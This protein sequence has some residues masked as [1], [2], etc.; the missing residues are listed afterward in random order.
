M[1]A[2]ICSI[3]CLLSNCLYAI[4]NPISGNITPSPG[5][6]ETYTIAWEN[7]NS[8]H[9]NMADVYWMVSNGTVLS[10]D[11][12]SATI[13]WN[14]TR[15]INEEGNIT[16][17]ENTWS[18]NGFLEVSL[19][20]PEEGLSENCNGI[21][22]QPLVFESFGSGSNPGPAY[23]NCSYAYKPYC[24]VQS[25]EYTR[26]N[27]TFACRSLWR[28]LPSDHTPND[29][30]GYMLLIDGDDKRGI[31]FSTTV[32]TGLTSSFQ[33]EFS[34][35][36]ANLTSG[37]GFE[38]PKVRFEIF[39]GATKIAESGDFRI[40]YD[41]N[42]PWQRISMMVHVPFGSTS[43]TILL[44][45]QN[46]DPDGNDFVVDD[47]S[48]APCY[49]PIIASF[50][51]TEYISKSYTCNNGTVNLFASWPPNFIIPF[52]NPQFKW[53]RS[54]NN[55]WIDIP[56]A[57]SM[58]YTQN[59]S[60]GGIYEYRVI[61][62]ESS[63]PS[64]YLTS[65]TLIYFVQK[66]VVDAKTFNIYSC[67]PSPV[68]LSPNYFLQY[69]DITGSAYY[70]N[71]YTWSPGT[72][73]SSTTI[74]APTISLPAL[75]PPN[76]NSSTTPPPITY[77]YT[78]SVQNIA[79]P[80]CSASNTITVLHHNPRKVVVPTAFTPNGDGVND[81]FRPLN[82]Q[83]Y[84]GGEFWVWNRWGNLVFYSQGPTLL[85]YSWNGNYSNGQPADLGNYVWR[86]S[87]PGCPN[88]IWNGAGGNQI[89]N[90]YGNVELIR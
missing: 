53:Q 43:L 62:F 27:S 16:V 69:T 84:P 34:A 33:Y 71:N 17:F 67:N 1:K 58:A 87:I 6:I 10:Y 8:E 82:L 89:N 23:P 13:Q 76:L 29:V 80:A 35:Y 77:T 37:S 22:G 24:A 44:I 60:V 41:V 65:N 85:N 73:L 5:S 39:N 19:Y 46:N 51:N 9:E 55:G 48:F 86:V 15:W 2:I 79:F 40:F 54:T 32:T 26:V 57:T 50:S 56:G 72:Y 74:S 70:Y 25:G 21:L 52:S 78:F 42:N 45:N 18:V 20:S 61:A 49:T 28:E 66:M 90:P 7:W 64:F 3:G 11:K 88:N 36:L 59:E 30:N 81:L 75:V 4:D 47:L 83:D 63:N 31:V 38:R 14:T 12:H 68:Q